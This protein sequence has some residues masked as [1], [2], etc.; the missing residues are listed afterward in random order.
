MQLQLLPIGGMYARG[1]RQVAHLRPYE[2]VEMPRADTRT[3]TLEYMMNQRIERTHARLYLC[4]RA[5]IQLQEKMP[6]Q[7]ETMAGIY[8]FKNNG[9]G[10]Y[11]IKKY[12]MK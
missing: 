2:V 11:Q 3:L 6:G 10:D 5:V 1:P 8:T 12:S 7:T 4:I 9:G